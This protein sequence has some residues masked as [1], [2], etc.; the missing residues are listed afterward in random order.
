MES[1]KDSY[2]RRNVFGVS[3]VEFFWGLGFPIVLE[4]TFLQ[5]FLKNLGASSFVIGLV[6]ALFVV[7]ISCFPL[8]SS[9]LSSFYRLKKILVLLLHL[10]SALSILM[11]GLTL[12]VMKESEHVLLLFFA[13]YTIFSICMGLTIPVWLNYLV[14]IFSESKTVPGLGYMMLA[15]NIGKVV[16]SFFILKVVDK[17]AF[18]L[19]SSAWIFICT[20]LVFI[21]GSLC[22]IFTKEI[23]DSDDPPANHLS[24]LHHTWISFVEISSNRRFLIYLIADLDFYVIITVLSFY[25]NYA[26]G[27]YQ[28]PDAIAAGLFVACIYAGS[29][30]VNIFLGAMNLLG[31]KQKFILSKCVT[32]VLLM[33][34][35]FL[36]S[37]I[38]FFLISYMLG[39]VRA[40]RNM[41]YPPSVKKFAE[42]TDATSYFALAPII[43]LPITAGYPLV[44]GKT[45]DYLHFMQEDA[46]KL[47]FGLSALFILITLYFSVKTDYE[48][49]KHAHDELPE[50][51]L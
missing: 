44:F 20:G 32:L 37:Y 8:F 21:V 6:P 27:F 41:V 23:A 26:T 9:Y 14:R 47:L 18:S 31:L 38:V 13:S 11:F 16:S 50:N 30:T 4:S 46:Y 1:Y 5:L 39:F 45:L 36:P 22:F 29:I 49:A 35:I 15:Q 51:I 24:F 12:L 17:Y 25:A 10:I 7:G 43:T 42:K 34:L 2:F 33:L 40:I 3:V 28:V 48:G 19:S